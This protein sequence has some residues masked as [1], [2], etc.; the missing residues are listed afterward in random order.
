MGDIVDACQRRYLET[1][2]SDEYRKADPATRAL[3]RTLC[4]FTTVKFMVDDFERRYSAAS[5]F[6]RHLSDRS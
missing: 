4:G 3:Y 1:L 6:Q 5:T 2:N